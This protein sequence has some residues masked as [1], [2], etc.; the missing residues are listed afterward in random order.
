M[1][2]KNNISSCILRFEKT[3]TGNLKDLEERGAIRWLPDLVMGF[4]TLIM[5]RNSRH[6]KEEA[7]K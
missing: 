6:M 1:I 4:Q 5:R 2:S 7:Q 3:M